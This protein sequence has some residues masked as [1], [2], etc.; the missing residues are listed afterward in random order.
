MTV[1]SRA[2]PLQAG[3][4]AVDVRLPE[5][6]PVTFH[7]KLGRQKPLGWVDQAG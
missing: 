5:N 4:G 2:A 7:L 1:G 6:K 3:K